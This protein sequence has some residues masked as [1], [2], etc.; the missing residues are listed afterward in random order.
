MAAVSARAVEKARLSRKPV[1]IEPGRY[2][3]ILE[4]QA[5]GDLVQLVG[6]YA[7]ARASDEGRSPFTKTGGGNKIGEK[8]IDARISIT[9]D[10]FDPMVLSQP[11]D[12]TVCHWAARLSS[13]RACSRSFT[14]LASGQR[15]RARPLPGR[16]HRSS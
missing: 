16:R 1:A 9:A 7:D 12:G 3:V 15:S 4:P 8:I 5:V 13:T 10:P 6:F 14:T 11:W 2:T